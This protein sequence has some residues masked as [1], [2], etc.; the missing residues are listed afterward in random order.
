MLPLVSVIMSVY[1][2]ERY[3]QRAVESI[4]AQTYKN[5]ELIVF[6][7]GSTDNTFAILKRFKEQNQNIHLQRLKKNIGLTN[8]LNKAIELS[9]GTYIARM[10]ADDISLPKRLEKQVDYLER[11]PQ[12]IAV[13]TAFKL[14]DDYGGLIKQ[15]Q[16]SNQ[17]HILK[18]NL[19]FFNPICHPSVVMRASSLKLLGGYHSQYQR[20]QDYELWWRMSIIG[21]LSNLTEELFIMR[22]HKR[23]VTTQYQDSQMEYAAMAVRQ[24]LY[25]L[26]GK[27]YPIQITKYI[28]GKCDTS[29]QALMAGMAMADYANFCLQNAPFSSRLRIAYD[30]CFKILKKT[31]RFHKEK[32]VARLWLRLPSLLLGIFN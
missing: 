19:L 27:E 23:R 25:A 20:A 29:E 13:G 26:L 2:G 32:E 15:Y 18:W 9:N 24:N 6:D 7:D 21:E 12:V 8:S 31:I 22:Q 4:L 28:R 5:I 1:N 10:D 17:H 11:N 30:A 3:L 16:F 14:I